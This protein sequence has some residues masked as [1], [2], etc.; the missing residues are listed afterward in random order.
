VS[1][2]EV[3]FAELQQLQENHS[4][5]AAGINKHADKAFQSSYKVRLRS[6]ESSMIPSNE[7]LLH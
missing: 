2:V 5:Q 1:T 3:H 7:F 4:S 6:V